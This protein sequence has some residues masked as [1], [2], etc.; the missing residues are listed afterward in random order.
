MELG[1]KEVAWIRD[2]LTGKTGTPCQWKVEGLDKEVF[3]YERRGRP[4]AFY[5]TDEST[6]RAADQPSYASLDEALASIQSRPV[7]RKVYV[8]R[9]WYPKDVPVE[10]HRLQVE[11]QYKPE[12]AGY[13]ET[14]QDAENDCISI[15]RKG[16]HIELP[17]GG[18]RIVEDFKVEQLGS[19]EFVIFCE[20][21]FVHITSEGEQ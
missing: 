7:P 16:I 3:I 11:F 6:K 20:D 14:W 21:P 2:G 17:S 9:T 18:R 8:G 1:T 5:I 15:F 12:N 13:Y 4:S 19:R 10:R